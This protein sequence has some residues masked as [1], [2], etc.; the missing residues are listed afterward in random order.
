MKI[1]FLNQKGVLDFDIQKKYP[2]IWTETDKGKRIDE[3]Y[4]DPVKGQI[5]LSCDVVIDTGDLTIA[6]CL[7]LMKAIHT[8]DK[9][10]NKKRFTEQIC[11][12]VV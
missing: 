7:R 1:E 12:A 11:E 9:I 2:L 10:E 5:E 6:D 3:F 4:V 8:L